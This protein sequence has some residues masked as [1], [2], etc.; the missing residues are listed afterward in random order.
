MSVAKCAEGGTYMYMRLHA[1][2][3]EL[4]CNVDMAVSAAYS[5]VLYG[6]PASG[7]DMLAVSVALFSDH[8][9]KYSSGPMCSN[10]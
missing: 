7:G 5:S 10:C 9:S 2:T 3:L 4:S 6:S 1:F 8:P